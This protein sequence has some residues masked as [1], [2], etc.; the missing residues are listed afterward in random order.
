MKPHF[1]LGKQ[2][3]NTQFAP[4][5]V[6]GQAF[7]ERQTLRELHQ[8]GLISLKT[9]DHTPGEKLS[10]AFLLVLAGYPSLYL[11]NTTLRADPSLA[12][13]WH[14]DSFAEQSGVSR[15]LDACTPDVL[16]AL[17]DVSFAFWWQ[18]SQL[19]QHDWRQRL[20]VDLDLSPL[21]ASPQAEASTKGYLGKKTLP[22]GNW[23]ESCCIPIGNRCSHNSIRVASTVV[24]VCKRRS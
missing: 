10:A 21:P 4:L 14:C 5:C 23:H 12:R 2:L 24:N 3:F 19:P 20:F 7:H 1:E 13:A 6:L 9:R 18:H 16:N 11:L 22:G 15:L 17:Q 8:P